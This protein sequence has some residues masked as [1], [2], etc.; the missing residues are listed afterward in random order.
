MTI[1]EMRV[2]QIAERAIPLDEKCAVVR[3]EQIKRRATLRIEIEELLRALKPY[4]PREQLKN[5]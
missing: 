4:D 5:A 2:K 3:S 1:T